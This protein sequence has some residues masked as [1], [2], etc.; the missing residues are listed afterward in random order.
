MLHLNS[1]QGF[2]FPTWYIRLVDSRWRVLT[3]PSGMAAFPRFPRAYAIQ[4]RPSPDACGAGGFLVWS[5]LETVAS[6]SIIPVGSLKRW[7]PFLLPPC[8]GGLLEVFR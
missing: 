3:P 1:R 7:P 6:T 8:G 5:A 4:P 2:D